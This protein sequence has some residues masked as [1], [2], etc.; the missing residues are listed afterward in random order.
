M[1]RPSRGPRASRAVSG[2][3]LEPD[4]G[5]LPYALVH[6]EPLVACA[7]WALGEAG[8]T[9]V[10]AGT[11][12]SSLVAAGEPVVLHDP[13]CPLTPPDF[14]ADC[15]RRA[16][17]HDRV[18]VGVRPVTDT[19][20]VV[21]DG[22]VGATLDRDRLLQV[23]LAGRA[24]GLRGRRRSTARRPRTSPPLVAPLAERYPVRARRGA[25]RPPAGSATRTTCGSSRR[26]PRVGSARP[27]SSGNV[28]L[29]LRALLGTAATRPSRVALERTP[30][31]R[32]P[33]TRR[34]RPSGTPRAAARPGTP[35]GSARRPGRPPPRR[36]R[37][38]SSPG[39]GAAGSAPPC[40]RAAA[41]TA[42]N[43]VERAS[44]RA[45]SWTATTS[46]SPASISAASTWS[47][48]HSEA[49]R[50]A[51]PVTSSASRSPS[52]R[53]DRVPDGGLLAGAGHQHEPAYVV[54]GE[55]RAHRPGEHRRCRRAGSS[56]L[57]VSAP[58]RL[59]E[60][61]ARITT[62]AGTGQCV[63]RRRFTRSLHGGAA[64]KRS[65]PNVR[66]RD[67]A[68]DRTPSR[69]GTR[70]AG[71]PSSRWSAASPRW[72][73]GRRW[74]SSGST[75]TPSTPWP[76]TTRSTG[77]PLL[78][79]GIVGARDGVPFV[80]SP[81]HKHAFDLR[82]G[83]CLD[84]PHVSVA[85][86][87]VKVVEGVVL[88]G[89]RK[90]AAWGFSE[91][92]PASGGSGDGVP[93]SRCPSR[94]GR[95]GRAV[96]AEPPEEAAQQDRASLGRPGPLGEVL[97]GSTRGREPVQR[98]VVEQPSLGD[99]GL[100]QHRLVEHLRA[101][102]DPRVHPLAPR[103]SA[104]SG[105]ARW[106][107][108]TACGTASPAPGPARRPAPSRTARPCPR[109]SR[110][111]RWSAAARRRGAPAAGTARAAP[112]PRG[113]RRA[114]RAGDPEELPPTDGWTTACSRVPKVCMSQ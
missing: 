88:I 2:L 106:P 18:V 16:V 15:V 38:S 41:S 109:R 31:C 7:A 65:R 110:R 62:A 61:A 47:A 108:G 9:L 72:C 90:T 54:D 49:C 14:L 56:T 77:S 45:P 6:G 1:G 40:S 8:V 111:P 113:G 102:D 69:S 112:P 20:K 94:S 95:S 60:P 10:D 78:A 42:A 59:P 51:P 19:V 103:A 80:A 86:Y 22:Y 55:R 79:R 35:A 50:V 33:R 53:R 32:C 3:V 73:T 36:A 98:R 97:R 82:T 25:A 114:G 57:L 71:S 46:T 75:R 39:S 43:S 63:V 89:H 96:L 27:T 29:R 76:T 70:C 58:T 64:P 74:R 66:L 30:R 87:D 84:D 12:W 101:V 92:S 28:I 104:P 81:V 93:A 99:R 85:A 37:R 17:E 67:A 11:P 34:R 100:A 21:E 105:C 24:A 83:Q 23:V 26:S 48:C 91:A 13:L 4:R 5:S 68:P 52:T 107:R 44:G